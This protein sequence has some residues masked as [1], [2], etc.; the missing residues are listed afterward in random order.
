[1]LCYTRAKSDI[2]R[3]ASH[4]IAERL[5]AEKQQR[6]EMGFDDLLTRLDDA[7]HGPRGDQLA[8]TIR[9]QFP[10]A[11][12]TGRLVGLLDLDSLRVRAELNGIG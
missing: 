12:R 6:S 10:V 7:L 3:H 8:A 11:D 9:R 5:E 4:W 1:M 2:L